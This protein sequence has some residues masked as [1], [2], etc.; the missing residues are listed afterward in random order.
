VLEGGLRMLRAIEA[1]EDASDHGPDAPWGA[2]NTAVPDR[3]RAGVAALQTA[4]GRRVRSGACLVRG[5]QVIFLDRSLAPAERLQVLLD[6]LAGRDVE[7]VYLSPALRRLLER[8][9]GAP[10]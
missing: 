9:S 2:C 3:A 7:T 4:P 1:D 8:G 5:E 10:A 6:E